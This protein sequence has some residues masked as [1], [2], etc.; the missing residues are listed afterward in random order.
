MHRPY[1]GDAANQHHILARGST[2][3]PY[4][5]PMFGTD[6]AATQLGP[7]QADEG[8]GPTATAGKL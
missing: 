3:L 7:W 8:G 2:H 4:A 6:C 1:E 5:Q